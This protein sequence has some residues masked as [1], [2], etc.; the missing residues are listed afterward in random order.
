CARHEYGN[1]LDSW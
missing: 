1:G